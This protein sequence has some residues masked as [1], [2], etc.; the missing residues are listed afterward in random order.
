MRFRL[1]ITKTQGKEYAAI[2]EDYYSRERRGSTSRTVRTYGDLVKKRLINPNIDKELEQEVA[3]LNADAELANHAW[4]VRHLESLEQGSDRVLKQVNYGVVFYRRIWEALKLHSWFDRAQRNSRGAIHY[5]LD[6]AVFLLVAMRIL[7]PMSKRKTFK[8][9]DELI[10]DFTQ[11]TLDNLYDCLDVLASKKKTIVSNLNKNLE[12]LYARVK[13]IAFYDV[14]TFYFE[15]FDSDELK[16]RE[17]SKENKTNEVQVVLGLLV[18]G[19]G[20]PI[21]YEL[22]R[23]NT[24]EM[25]TILEVVSHYR[26][27]NHLDRITVVADRGLN[28]Y[29][30][31]K[32]LRA[33]NFDYIVAQSIDR[34]PSEIKR[35]ALSQDNWDE[36]Y[37]SHEEE[38]FKVKRIDG[39]D[40]FPLDHQIIVTWSAKR[41]A[42]DLKVLNERYAKCKELVERG[43]GAVNA[44]IKHGT[45]QFLRIKKGSN[46]D[47]STN[48]S[49]YEKRIAHAGFYALVTS[50]KDADSF[51]IYRD[52][53]QL[54]RIEAC[55][56]VMKSTLEARPVFVWTPN[57]IRG[58]FLVCYLALVIERFANYRARR[59]NIDISSH[60]MI[61]ILQQAKMVILEHDK[62]KKP[63]YLRQGI[64][65][66]SQKNAD[67]VASL[68]QLLSM[69][70]IQSLAGVEDAL[71]LSRKFKVSSNAKFIS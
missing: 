15:S 50:R 47:Y 14:T 45:R 11:L 24:S 68:D 38:T 49:L 23:G 60:R 41:Q 52:L 57:R 34:L 29:F 70:G 55:F 65:A 35:K 61:E 13:T 36:I 37:A 8:A 56:R 17:M 12:T 25:K 18:D 21:D 5:D 67:Y 66:N 1:K 48:E 43:A 9:R 64:S 31:L 62:S 46:L 69:V 4:L 16:A 71:G 40:A 30:N 3:R 59:S 22:F 2:V 10:F 27:T 44:S 28:S 6:L 58:H 42:H 32:E 54:W 7:S 63:L 20:I 26:E 39:S 33:M 19:E 51:E 53:R